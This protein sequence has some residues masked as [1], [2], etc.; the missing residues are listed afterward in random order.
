MIVA[1][2]DPSLTSTGVAIIRSQGTGKPTVELHSV[3]TAGHK[4]DGYDASCL[5][6]TTIRD[7][8]MRLIPR[9]ADLVLMEGPA[10]MSNTGK[11]LERNWLWGKL[12]DAL[13][14]CQLPKVIIVPVKVKQFAAGKGNA[15]KIAVAM[16]VAKMW[17]GVDV[18][19][20]DEADAL[21]MATMGWVHLGG[22]VWFNVLERHREVLAKVVWP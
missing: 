1:A 5:R 20:D 18:A 8:V 4:G 13:V 11:V 16:A 10:F 17:P 12:Y 15:D 2:I 7:K 22:T 14:A 9:D 21:A 6:I 19:S 3:R